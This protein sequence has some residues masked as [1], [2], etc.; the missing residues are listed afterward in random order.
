MREQAKTY[1]VHVYGALREVVAA[2][3]IVMLKTSPPINFQIDF[4]VASTRRERI[5]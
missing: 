5:P 1:T 4:R 2:E 3:R